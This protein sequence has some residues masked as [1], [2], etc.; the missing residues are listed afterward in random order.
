MT[1]RRPGFTILVHR[2]GRVD[3]RSY[4]IP[5]WV[6]RAATTAG[7]RESRPSPGTPCCS[8]HNGTMAWDNR[9]KLD[10]D[11]STC[12]LFHVGL[13]G[14]RLPGRVAADARALLGRR[15]PLGDDRGGGLHGGAWLW[16]C[17]HIFSYSETT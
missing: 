17:R 3:S 16:Q 6:L 8:A 2:D 9:F 15:R 4:R 10:A 5:L 7:A 13:C 11:S 14:P 1:A 12:H